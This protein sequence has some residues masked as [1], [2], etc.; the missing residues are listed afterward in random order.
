MG[1]VEYGKV[2][3]K[4]K[5]DYDYIKCCEMESKVQNPRFM[6]A[7]K[8]SNRGFSELHETWK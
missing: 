5:F 3:I 7:T 1:E 6:T 8:A 4:P 2:I